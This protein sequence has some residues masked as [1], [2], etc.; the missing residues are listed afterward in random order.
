[1]ACCGCGTGSGDCDACSCSS[2][3]LQYTLVLSGITDNTCTEPHE[4]AELNSTW[5]LTKV[6]GFCHW[7]VTT[8]LRLCGYE[9]TSIELRC[10]SVSG[11]WELDIQSNGSYAQWRLIIASWSCLGSNTLSL[12]TSNN[13]CNNWP[14]S[15]TLNPV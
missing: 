5:T 11:Y 12:F 13:S 14:S 4:C 10:N 3:P 9:P 7:G 1:M 8:G 6:S 2:Y 15:V